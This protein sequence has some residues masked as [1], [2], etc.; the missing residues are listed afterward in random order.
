MNRYEAM[1]NE[2]L[3]ELAKQRVKKTGCF[4]KV[5][6]AAQKELWK[7]SH[8]DVFDPT[9]FGEGSERDLNDLQYNG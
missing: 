2:E 3:K 5:A 1:S 8:W 7:R 6:L 4:S 9:E